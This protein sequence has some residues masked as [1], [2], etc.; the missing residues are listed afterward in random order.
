[1]NRHHHHIVLL[2]VLLLGA[3][4]PTRPARAQL[5]TPTPLPDLLT[6][7]CQSHSTPRTIRLPSPA[8]Q[9]WL[10]LVAPDRT[11]ALRMTIMISAPVAMQIGMATPLPGG[12]WH[13]GRYLD[14]P[15]AVPVSLPVVWNDAV[16]AGTRLA[17][18][19]AWRDVAGD[20]TAL[21][22]QPIELTSLRM[23]RGLDR[24]ALSW[25]TDLSG[26]VQLELARGDA[27]AQPI[28]IMGWDA[29]GQPRG[30]TPLQ[31]D[32]AQG[33]ASW[34]TSLAPGRWRLLATLGGQILAE[35]TI[36]IAPEIE[37]QS[38]RPIWLPIVVA[39]GAY[40]QP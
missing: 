26:P 3:L 4:I 13:E 7:T 15:N 10:P 9:P 11:D 32:A 34:G 12:R 30:L 18:F 29:Y 35:R 17:L 25:H 40:S 5:D 6:A 16:E 23:T 1:M 31:A 14:V 22:G 24:Y 19:Y 36:E 20:E 33:W 2:I 27:P 28:S 37:P 38:C 21:Y 39:P 8:L